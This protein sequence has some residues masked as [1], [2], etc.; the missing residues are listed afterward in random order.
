MRPGLLQ[1]LER[2]PRDR[3][4]HQHLHRD[5]RTVVDLQDRRLVPR[6]QQ[7]LPEVGGLTRAGPPRAYCFGA[8]GAGVAGALGICMPGMLWP[9]C[10]II[11]MLRQHAQP[12]A[13]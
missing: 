1:L 3:P 7:R 6:G 5:L 9:G 13:C 12:P 2:G 8:S 4:V 11:A 10:C